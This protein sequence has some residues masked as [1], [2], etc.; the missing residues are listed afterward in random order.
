MLFFMT[1]FATVV[2][3]CFLIPQLVHLVRVGDASGVSPHAAAIGV[4]QTTSWALYGIGTGA[5]AVV[6]PSAIAI[7]QY[8]AVV[9]LATSA[10]KRSSA[11]GQGVLAALAVL[12]A[13]GASALGGSGPWPGLGTALTMAVVWQYLPA[14]VEAYRPTGTRGLS[15]PTWFLIGGNGL[16]WAAYGVVTR[17]TAVTCYGVVLVSAAAAVLSAIYVHAERPPAPTSPSD[18]RPGGE[19]RALTSAGA[20]SGRVRSALASVGTS[21]PSVPLATAGLVGLF[22]R[23]RARTGASMK[24]QRPNPLIPRADERA[25]R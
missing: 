6:V 19:G 11:I 10:A 13:A 18:H 16:S 14:V 4:V 8:V 24:S 21:R 17:A 9:L 1:G 12:V 25:R 3:C 15:C 5:W 2:G 20:T 7:P 22:L 23:N